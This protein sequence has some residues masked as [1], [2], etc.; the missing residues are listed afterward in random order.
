MKKLICCILL[1][2]SSISF[3]MVQKTTSALTH[4]ERLAAFYALNEL[5]NGYC[6]F[7]YKEKI[8]KK[9]DKNDNF[10]L[11]ESSDGIF[12][13]TFLEKIYNISKEPH[14]IISVNF[15][16]SKMEELLKLNY[17]LNDLQAFDFA[18]FV[19]LY[20]ANSLL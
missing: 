14:T 6:M 2:S 5:Q 7:M 8:S 11:F 20:R 16:V 1:L 18:S 4:E 13:T 19:E 9:C 17:T 10:L 12:Y 15:T 3:A